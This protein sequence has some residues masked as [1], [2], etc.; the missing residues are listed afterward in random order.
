MKPTHLES[1]LLLLLAID[2]TVTDG[3]LTLTH[4]LFVGHFENNLPERGYREKRQEIHS[5]QVSLRNIVVARAALARMYGA[6]SD[7]PGKGEPRHLQ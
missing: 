1:R 5:Y 6:K 3:V 7:G 2:A 4:D